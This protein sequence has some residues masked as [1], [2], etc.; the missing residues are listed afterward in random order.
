MKVYRVEDYHGG[1]PYRGKGH[2]KLREMSYKHN[3]ERHP[4][5]S[6]DGIRDRPSSMHVCG[7]ANLKQYRRWFDA[8]DRR[9][10]QEKKFRL[11]IYESDD[12]IRGD[13]QVMFVKKKRLGERAL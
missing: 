9:E 5:P 3:D 8:V 1:G 6:L 7:F 11:R 2:K 12:V 13:N 4:V 10:L